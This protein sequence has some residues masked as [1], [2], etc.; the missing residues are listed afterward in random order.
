MRQEPL[1]P[2]LLGESLTL[3]WT[4][5]LLMWDSLNKKMSFVQLLNLSTLCLAAWRTSG[6]WGFIVL[7]NP[8][9]TS[10]LR[11]WEQISETEKH[12]SRQEHCCEL[13][14]WAP[15]FTSHAGSAVRSQCGPWPSGYPS[16]SHPTPH[17]ASAVHP[18]AAPSSRLRTRRGGVV[19]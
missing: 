12:R 17:S 1:Q 3:T 7:G 8:G 13:G 9:F 10:G 11:V 2:G 4:R 19:P 14:P 16:A 5:A 6:S 18:K 15:C